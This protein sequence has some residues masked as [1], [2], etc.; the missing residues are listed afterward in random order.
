M[1]AILFAL[2]FATPT[3]DFT[4]EVAAPHHIHVLHDGIDL[5][6]T[7]AGT[8]YDGSHM[9]VVLDAIRKNGFE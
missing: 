5:G 2:L 7:A 6:R 9:V 1:N 3:W 4:A 8:V